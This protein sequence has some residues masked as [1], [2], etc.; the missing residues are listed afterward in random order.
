M[1]RN[2]FLFGLIL[3]CTYS[4][5]SAQS[6]EQL[7]QMFFDLPDIHFERIDDIEGQPAY[8]IKLK[9][10]TDH[11]NPQNGFF[12]QRIL[13]IHRG[14]DKPT[15]I[16]TNGYQ[17]QKGPT[18]LIEL[19]DANYISVEHRYFGPSTP[20]P[21]NWQYLNMQQITTDYHHIKEILG[22]VY[23]N[24][25]ISTGISKGGETCTY[26]RHFYPEDVTATIAYVAPF[27]NALKDQ[28]IYAFLDTIG[29]DHCRRK[30]L[31][32]QMTLLKK[33]K[34]LMP[35]FKYYVMGK[36]GSLE[37][38]GGYEAAY[39][40]I[41]MEFPF[42]HF[43][44]GE[45]CGDIPEVDADNETLINHILLSGTFWYFFDDFTESLAAHYYQHATQLG[46]YG[47]LTKP[48]GDLIKHWEEEPSACFFPFD[49]PLNFDA[50]IQ[51]RLINWLQTKAENVMF[52]Y[53]G[54]DTWT[55]CQADIGNNKNVNKYILPGKH[56][57]SARIK[58]MDTAI[59]ES[60][61]D[62]M[63]LWLK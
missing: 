31:D 58:E 16:N 33:K 62:I 29:S 19:L 34:E 18:E 17:L 56:H 23:H 11:E 41:V 50:S 9:Q 3:C 24:H 7:E 61:K 32:Y 10:S 12:Y 57:G 43:Q 35:M 60:W 59:L 13:L 22:Q 8:H 20:E 25:W 52:I 21:L 47:Y 4:I 42:G 15:V 63:A 53:G 45:N 49:E 26:Y 40:L 1:T 6:T 48:F 37:L 36:G 27:P 14:F 5:L 44:G 46:Y 54:N 28:R 30:I 51:P 2:Y 55:A 39:E 38:L